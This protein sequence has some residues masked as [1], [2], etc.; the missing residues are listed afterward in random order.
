[1]RRLTS[2]RDDDDDDDDHGRG[3]PSPA[4]EVTRGNIASSPSGVLGVF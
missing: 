2:Y 4:D 1:M 3:A